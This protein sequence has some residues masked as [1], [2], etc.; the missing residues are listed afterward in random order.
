MHNAL[1]KHT[2]MH[3]PGLNAS[4]IETV[5]A[6]L[7]AGEVK[8]SKI[9]GEIALVYNKTETDALALGSATIRINNFP[10]LEG[11]YS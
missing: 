4:F 3:N 5:N 1:V 2:E 11:T 8:S 9:N 6:T 10:N 7:V